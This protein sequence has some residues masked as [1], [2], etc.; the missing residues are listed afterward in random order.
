MIRH[1]QPSFMQRAMQTIRGM[2][3]DEDELFDKSV[4]RE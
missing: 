1:Q 4:N 2:L 3:A